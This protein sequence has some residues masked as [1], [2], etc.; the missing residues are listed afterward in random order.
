[1]SEIVIVAE[2][3][4][5]EVSDS[6]RQE[7]EMLRQLGVIQLTTLQ[8]KDDEDCEL[9]WLEFF[10]ADEDKNCVLYVGGSE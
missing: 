5:Q 6:Q 9:Q 10:N 8:G 2:D 3:I 7:L 4:Q 1:V